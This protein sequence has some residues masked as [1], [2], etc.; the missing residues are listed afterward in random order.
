[1][2]AIDY[3]GGLGAAAQAATRIPRMQARAPGWLAPAGGGQG[4][5]QGGQGL[6]AMMDAA[7]AGSRPQGTQPM[8]RAEVA[9]PEGGGAAKDQP[10]AY[11][12]PGLVQREDLAPL[13]PEGVPVAMTVEPWL[14]VGSGM[15]PGYA[16]GGLASAPMRRARRV[17]S[18]GLVHSAS[19]GRAD[20]V[21]ARLRRGSYVLPADVVSGL[22]EGNTLAGAK[23]LQASLPEAAAMAARGPINRAAGGLA[24]AEDELEVRLSG[25]EFLVSPEQVLAIGEGDVEAGAKALDDLVHTVRGSTREALGRMPPPK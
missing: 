24:E 4:Q 20:L 1:M 22:G 19:P 25:G 23:L 21:G 3:E 8:P 7:R 18:S 16:G 5:G 11:Q 14:G 12:A 17:G 10:S 2:R 9:M 15:P 6:G 13:V